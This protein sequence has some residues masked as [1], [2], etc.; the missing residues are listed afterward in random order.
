MT[1]MT[2]RTAIEIRAL[3][4]R[5]TN[6]NCAIAFSI[7]DS[8]KLKDRMRLNSELMHD[9]RAMARAGLLKIDRAARVGSSSSGQGEIT[10]RRT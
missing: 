2:A 9:A 3:G 8:R 4:P 6:K 5:R 1:T 10:C 7:D